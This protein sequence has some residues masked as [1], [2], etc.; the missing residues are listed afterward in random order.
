MNRLVILVV[1]T[2]ATA[3]AVWAALYFGA[4]KW[5]GRQ[6]AN[7]VSNQSTDVDAWA[8]AVETIKEVRVE[9][10]DGSSA[11]VTPAELR[12]YTDRQWFLATQVAEIAKYNV[13]TCQDYVDLAAMIERR[14]LVPVPLVTDTYVLYG[15]GEQAD[16]GAFSRYHD[17]KSI[18]VYDEA[19]LSEAYRSLEVKRSNL[20]SEIKSLQNSWLSSRNGIGRNEASSKNSLPRGSRS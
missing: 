11:V 16:D 1:V 17:D 4:P 3:V 19:Q 14:E 6:P 8:R 12:H 18:D 2:A 7:A 13:H 15:I 20:Q 5:F 9:T 10:Q